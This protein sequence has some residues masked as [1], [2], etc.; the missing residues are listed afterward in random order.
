MLVYIGTY[1]ESIRFGTG[2]MLR[3]SGKGIHILR[4]DETTGALEMVDVMAGVVNPSY[5]TFDHGGKFLYAV[6]ELKSYQEK[7]GGLR[8]LNR[9]PTDGT[10]PCHVTVDAERK[11]LFVANFM[12]GSVCVL[13]VRD[14]GS[15][16]HISDFVQHHGASIDPVRQ[17]GPHAHSV[18][19][20]KTNRIAFVPD[21]GLDR[22]FIY[23]FDPR[24]GMLHPNTVPWIEM[25][26]GSGPRH[27]ALHPDGT[28]LYLVN[29]LNSTIA[30]LAF[31]PATG[32]PR[33]LQVIST[34][35]DGFHGE[36]TCADVQLSPS[37]DFLYASNRGHD[38]IA[39]FAVDQ[40]SGLLR[41]IDHVPTEGRTPRGFGIDPSGEFLLVANQD[42]D[43]I[44]TFRV[45][46]LTGMLIPTG[47]VIQ[48]PTPVCVTFH[49]PVAKSNGERAWPR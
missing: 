25:Q 33:V 16:D 37:G 27:V 47:H 2:A 23:H 43:S 17:T 24:R 31:D 35:P 10:D 11:H 15:L 6:N 26:P 34:L 39:I 21:L 5:L 42:S 45:D 38:S 1:T 12:S 14:D 7:T 40:H 32:T 48:V 29:E 4:M 8:L 9:Q 3:G 18:T 28:M 46:A 20:D 49:R 44:V 41:E 30:T 13:R 36:N 19:L 22:L